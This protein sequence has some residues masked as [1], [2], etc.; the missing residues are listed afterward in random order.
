VLTGTRA[1]A[2]SPVRRVELPAARTRDSGSRK[3]ASRHYSG[4]TRAV[5]SSRS[6]QAPGSWSTR[7]ARR[8]RIDTRRARAVHTGGNG[9]CES[10]CRHDPRP[11]DFSL[12]QC[13]ESR[14]IPPI[15]G[16][17]PAPC[18]TT[19][20]PARRRA[21]RR[22]DTR[23][24]GARRHAQP[25]PPRPSSLAL[26]RRRGRTRR[27]PRAPGSPASTWSSSS[28][29]CTSPGHARRHHRTACA[30]ADT[31]ASAATACSSASSPTS[32]SRCRGRG[33]AAIGERRRARGSSRSRIDPRS[34]RFLPRSRLAASRPVPHAQDASGAIADPQTAHLANAARARIR[35]RRARTARH[36]RASDARAPRA[37]LPIVS[38]LVSP[39][40]AP[41]QM[42]ILARQPV[43]AGSTR[44]TNRADFGVIE[45]YCSAERP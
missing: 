1:R 29:T 10:A 4:S 3:T 11:A 44:S 40:N 45:C 31:A 41:Y 18:A 36:D 7:C 2:W 17:P 13:S 21:S 23:R 39:L 25:S 15:T 34:L 22:A 24:F 14:R 6:A 26:E 12:Q 30:P 32:G 16:S 28:A 5:A 27:S 33:A 43:P 9:R 35:C 38:P 8:R 37:A 42:A 20:L 19:A